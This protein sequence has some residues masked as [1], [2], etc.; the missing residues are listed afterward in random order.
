MR[1]LGWEG[2]LNRERGN[3]IWPWE[4]DTF[5]GMPL[6]ALFRDHGFSTCLGFLKK[7]Q[8]GGRCW[9]EFGLMEMRLEEKLMKRAVSF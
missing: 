4:V 2:Q 7:G 9:V 8:Q 3:G 6:E 5:T 1:E